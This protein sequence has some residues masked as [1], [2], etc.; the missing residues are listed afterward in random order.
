MKIETKKQLKHL[1]KIIQNFE[2]EGCFDL[3]NIDWVQPTF[4]I[5]LSALL[6][7]NESEIINISSKIQ[8]YLD[9]IKFPQGVDNKK[10]F[11]NII[12]SA[13]KT[14]SPIIKLKNKNIEEREDFKNIFLNKLFQFLPKKQEK[15]NKSSY[16]YPLGELITNIFEHSGEEFGYILLQYYPTKKVFE[17]CIVDTGKGFAKNYKENKN[18]SLSDA[19]AIKKALSGVSTKGE[20]RGFGLRTS[21]NLIVKGMSGEFILISGK[22]I[23]ISNQKEDIISNIPIKWQGVIISYKIPTPEKKIDFAI[24]LE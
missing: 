7:K 1:F 13:D 4:I 11:E 21:K 12:K 15:G 10:N 6:N 19:E 8:G 9:A 3:S 24:F 23:Y 17:V 5:P 2:K 22:A 18:I 16:L 14:Y 20:E